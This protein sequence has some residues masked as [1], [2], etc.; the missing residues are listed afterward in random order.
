MHHHAMQQPIM[1]A[2]E[3]QMLRNKTEKTLKTSPQNSPKPPQNS[4][5]LL[6]HWH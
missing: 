6:P 3:M 5:K 4:L 1:H 2:Y